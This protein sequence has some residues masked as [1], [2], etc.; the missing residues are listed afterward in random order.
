[1]EKHESPVKKKSK[2]GKTILVI[3]L[4]I[5]AGLVFISLII[6]AGSTSTTTTTVTTTQP[7]ETNSQQ[8]TNTNTAIAGLGTPV[9]DGKFEF[10]VTNVDCNKTQIG[11][12]YINKQAQGKFC[13]LS[14]SVKNIGDVPQTLNSSD[15]KVFNDKGQEYTN[16]SSAEIYLDNN[17][18]LY[19][20]I[21]PGNTVNG[22]FVFDVPTEAVLVKAELHDSSF[23][24][25][26]VVSLQ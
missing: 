9:R 10:T 19:K 11:D 17:D 21:N 15:Q 6:A 22:K 8:T 23:S 3:I 2:K 13:I 18:V 7:P 12:Q 1:M 26:V 4:S 24:N 20:D 14:I 5:V 16:D 25:G